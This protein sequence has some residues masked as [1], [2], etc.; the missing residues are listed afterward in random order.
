MRWI[1]ILV[2]AVLIL[3][4]TAY[5]MRH[6][7][8]SNLA[9]ASLVDHAFSPSWSSNE[10]VISSMEE[11]LKRD[12]NDPKAASTLGEAYLQR[13]RESGDPA[14]YAKAE[15][16]FERALKRAPDSVDAML[17]KASLLMARHEFHKAKD[18][19]RKAIDTNPDVVATYGILTD[20]FVE[21]GDYD[22]AI[23]TLDIMIRRKPNLSSYSRVSYIREL[24]GDVPGAI[25]AM[26]MAVESGAPNAENTAWC[27]VQLGNLYLNDGQMNRAEEQYQQA[28]IRF[29][30]Y[31][32][33]VAGLAKVASASGD[34]ASAVEHYKLA[35][36]R[37]P[38]AEF[39]IGLGDVYERMG[40]HEEAKAQFDLVDAIQELYRSNGVSVDIELAL[41]NA[42]RG[43]NISQALDIAEKEWHS[44]KSVR[45]ADV[46]AWVLYRAGRYEEAR[47]MMQQA[48]RLGTHDPLFLRHAEVIFGERVSTR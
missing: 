46:Y 2:I 24:M 4:I 27:M 3:G 10:Q 22:E 15:L 8:V 17:G 28:L 14:N 47:Q 30:N 41:F 39:A 34:L 9:A 48:L 26:K 44:R 19:A 7:S 1:R 36:D 25:Q 18:V 5:A 45:V 29:P 37:I 23:R 31:A 35:M 21:L 33:A 16:L 38:L 20:A 13:A 6:R 32:H 12:P 11:H 42:D 43:R 40:K